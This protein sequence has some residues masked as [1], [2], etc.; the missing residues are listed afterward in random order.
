M[1]ADPVQNREEEQVSGSTDAADSAAAASQGGGTSGQPGSRS[2]LA[3]AF[4]G[5]Y[6]AVRLITLLVVCLL[7]LVFAL[8]WWLTQTDR[9]HAQLVRY[10]E[11]YVSDTILTGELRI[12]RLDG[13]VFGALLLTDVELTDGLGTTAISI[14]SIA[15]RY[16]LLALL[17]LR[18]SV[19]LLAVTGADVRAFITPDGGLNL[20]NLVLPSDKVPEPATSTIQVDIEGISLSSSSFVMR[21]LRND[22]ARLVQ[23]EE[24]GVLGEF[25]LNPDFSMEVAVEELSSRVAPPIALDS[26][27]PVVLRGITAALAGPSIEASLATVEIGRT[28][29]EQLA[30]HVDLDP[31][32]EQLFEF[33]EADLPVVHIDPE[34]ANALVPGL[35]LLQPVDVRTFIEGTPADL[36]VRLEADAKGNPARL[37]FA[38]DITDPAVPAY[39][40][41]VEVVRFHPHQVIDLQGLTADVSALLTVRGRGITPQD[42]RAGLRLDVGPSTVMGYGIEYA[43]LT[44]HATYGEFVLDSLDAA[45][46]G[47]RLRAN[48]EGNLDGSVGLDVLLEAPDLGLVSASVPQ[49]GAL[50][51]SVFADVHVRGTVPV[52]EAQQIAALPPFE[53]LQQLL[54]TLQIDGGVDVENLEVAGISIGGLTLDA[55]SP[56]GEVPRVN[57]TI[58]VVD[59]S[60]GPALGAD[61]IR[62]QSELRTDRAVVD[63]TMSHAATRRSADIGLSADWAGNRA[64]VRVSRLQAAQEPMRV[65][66][67]NA[68]TVTLTVD[69]AWALQEIEL[70]DTA[71]RLVNAAVDLSGWYAMDG[72]FR[73]AVRTEPIDL[74]AVNSVFQLL[75]ELTGQA[76]LTASATGSLSQPLVRLNMA[77]A[78]VSSGPVEDFDGTLNVSVGARDVSVDGQ[79]RLADRPLARI[80]TFAGGFPVSINLETGSYRFDEER[81]FGIRAQMFPVEVAPFASRLQALASYRPRGQVSG[82]FEMTGT[83]ADPNVRGDVELAQGGISLSLPVSAPEAPVG[84]KPQMQ[85]IQLEGIEFIGATEYAYFTRPEADWFDFVEDLAPDSMV[86]RMA[87]REGSSIAGCPVHPLT[88]RADTERQELARTGR[89]GSA[90]LRAA[91][92]LDWRGC[93][94]STFDMF[95]DADLRPMFDDPGALVLWLKHIAGEPLRNSERARAERMGQWIDALALELHGDVGPVAASALPDALLTLTGATDFI[96][97]GR[98]DISATRLQGTA[99]MAA[100]VDHVVVEGIPAVTSVAVVRLDE[101]GFRAETTVGIGETV[102]ARTLA[103]LPPFVPIPP[104]EADSLVGPGDGLVRFTANYPTTFPQVMAGQADLNQPLS[105][106]LHVIRVPIL[107][108]MDALGLTS[109]PNSN[110]QS[111]DPL[112]M[113]REAALRGY[114]DVTGTASEPSVFGRLA[115]RGVYVDEEEEVAAGLEFSHV[116]NTLQSTAFIQNRQRSLLDAQVDLTLPVDFR[117]RLPDA[118]QW[119][120]DVGLAARL[121]VDQANLRSLLPTS[122]VGTWLDEVS[123]MVTTHINIGRTIAN[124]SVDGTMLLEGGRLGIIP[125]GRRFDRIDADVTF[126][127]ERIEIATFNVRD[128]TGQVTVEGH[129]GMDALLPRDVDLTV[130]LNNFLVADMSGMGIY[131]TGDV[132]MQGETSDQIFAPTITLRDL[133][134]DATSTSSSNVYGPTAPP[135]TI[136]WIDEDVAADQVGQRDPVMLN[137][138]GSTELSIPLRADIRIVTAGRNRLRHSLADAQF[139]IDLVTRLRGTSYALRGTVR[140]PSGQVSVAGKQFDITRGFV[141]F[142]GQPDSANPVIDFRA[143]HTLASDVAARLEPASSGEANVTVVVDGTVEDMFASGSDAIRLQSDPQLSQE[144]IL[145]VLLTGRP[146]DSESEVEGDQQALATASSLAAG[147]L[148]DQLLSAS[149][150]PIDTIRIDGDAQSGQAFARVEGGKY[151]GDNLYVGATYINSTDVRENDFE[152]SLE[153][154][155]KRFGS[156]SVRAEMRGGN[157]GNGGLELLY[158]LTRPGRRR[159]D[160][161]PPVMAPDADA[162]GPAM[163]RMMVPDAEPEGSGEPSTEV[164]ESWDT[165]GADSDSESDGPASQAP[166]PESEEGSGAGVAP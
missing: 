70:S 125:L 47:A 29:M 73:A 157:R 52:S 160:V 105:A 155:I 6:R 139:E 21:D 50:A 115:L 106:R 40:G 30:L 162:T 43:W 62:V 113:V 114:V 128:S 151:I 5:V 130:G 7:G 41:R 37:A 12:G 163:M 99:Q 64:R 101:E 136:L 92:W 39:E 158:N 51:G 69:D 53:M 98:V 55:T 143:Q 82:S 9:G 3:L 140:V 147:L 145:F 107:P 123:G 78:N 75:P 127:N 156:A 146:R 71:L 24:L 46:L 97:S 124:P 68:P 161:P 25:H 159:V 34:E 10:V 38:F 100:A 28:G 103:S 20:A 54:Q 110:S 72:R 165:F 14:D 2:V 153:W 132:E 166:T 48:A 79:M 44:A 91:V 122:I 77:A 137:A 13:P 119:F 152:L 83:I 144:D 65:R 118:A 11:D 61:S 58:N 108:W 76:S 96:G 66:L 120:G 17:Q 16:D 134:V 63:L 90:G 22:G 33:L 111:G 56:Q 26:R 85:L 102:L 104:D 59:A 112:A 15:L 149:G 133:Q 109:L 19:E 8:V 18:V 88:S 84:S 117:N 121:D 141:T 148:A 60:L 27:F 138:S 93:P 89:E 81:E 154:I 23:V 32:G 1:T 86:P 74:E 95:V 126:S 49:A 80:E 4:K 94:L 35:N 131:V 116:S 87:L 31:L 150:I 135:S 129:L 42:A 142:N 36:L 45:G 67:E 164:D 57:A